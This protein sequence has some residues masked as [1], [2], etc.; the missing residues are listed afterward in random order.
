MAKK[1]KRLC[2]AYARQKNLQSPMDTVGTD[3][4]DHPKKGDYV[5][6]SLPPRVA[7]LIDIDQK[8]LSHHNPYVHNFDT[9]GPNEQYLVNKFFFSTSHVICVI[10]GIGVGKT[11]FV[12]FFMER[13]LPS[14]D[15]ANFTNPDHSAC[16]IYLDIL[17]LGG[18]AI[19]AEHT[20]EVKT[21]FLELLCDR[22]EHEFI[23]RKFFDRTQEVGQIWDELLS[24]EATPFRR[25]PAL[26]RLATALS[27]IEE[28]KLTPEN[29]SRMIQER[30]QIRI[31][32]NKDPRIRAFYLAALLKHVKASVYGSHPGGIFLI[33][34]NLDQQEAPI[35]NAI[36]LALKPFSRNSE[37]KTIITARQ[38]TFYQGNLSDKLSEPVDKVAYS[39]ASVIEVIR[40][41]VSRF[42]NSQPFDIKYCKPEDIPHLLVFLKRLHD[43]AL[44]TEL[45]VSFITSLCGHS[46]R[47]GL[48]LAQRL[49]NNSVF[50]PIEIGKSGATGLSTTEVLRAIL[51][52]TEDSYV[53]EVENNIIENI[54]QVQGNPGVH[55]LAKLRLLLILKGQSD[56]RVKLSRLISFLDGFGYDLEVIKDTLNE[57]LLESKRLIWSDSVSQFPE[58]KSL[59]LQSNSHIFLSSIGEGYCT[60]LFKSLDYLQEVMLDTDV[61]PSKFGSNWDYRKIEHRFKLVFMFCAELLSQ[62]IAETKLFVANH[63]P[64]VYEEIFGMRHLISKEILQSISNHIRGVLSHMRMRIQSAVQQE[65][66]DQFTAET[67]S[68]F[69]DRIILAEN[70][71]D[72][73]FSSRPRTRLRKV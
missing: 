11:S 48:I 72:E 64:G 31:D 21:E 26:S 59:S 12:T 45:V 34:D 33:I 54:F 23:S 60:Y 29:Y 10:G 14:V 35:Q 46:T 38:N 22:I 58:T 56:H 55:N 40:E 32:L 73:L 3:I 24:E 28:D 37:V 17:D 70:A 9:F 19:L 47:K 4:F 65:G 20:E 66:F 63:G 42:I 16:V 62:D 15:S 5:L 27:N 53:Y 50:D 51:V 41:R 18:A 61:S 43:H 68:S 25:N 69:R 1:L 13:V 57:L 30:K 2:A 44:N 52:G 8:A 49:V 6:S 36:V 7:Y 71:E 39:G 67:L